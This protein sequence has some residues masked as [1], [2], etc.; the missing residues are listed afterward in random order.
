MEDKRLP[1]FERLHV[2]AK[3]PTRATKKSAGYDLFPLFELV[4]P[5][6]HQNGRRP[7]LVQTGVK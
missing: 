2:G 3:L 1:L 7:A 5:R 4:I 6:W